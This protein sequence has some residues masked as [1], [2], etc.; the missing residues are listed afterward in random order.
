MLRQ[1]FHLYCA[2]NTGQL[3]YFYEYLASYLY[4][5]VLPS[6]PPAHTKSCLSCLADA[7]VCD[8]V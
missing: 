5:P 1:Q 6:I 3:N 8:Q 4:P 2:I 7:Q